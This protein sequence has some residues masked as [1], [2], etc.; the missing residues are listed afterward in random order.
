M[1]F[2]LKAEHIWPTLYN[3]SKRIYISR[4]LL[5]PDACKDGGKWILHAS[6]IKQHI[7]DLL[8]LR[9]SEVS[10]NSPLQV[11]LS[12]QSPEPERLPTDPS[13][14]RPIS[15]DVPWLRSIDI[16]GHSF[17]P[18]T[19]KECHCPVDLQFGKFATMGLITASVRPACGCFCLLGE[20]FGLMTV[21]AQLKPDLPY[22]HKFPCLWSDGSWAC[23]LFSLHGNLSL[24]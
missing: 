12:A 21:H 9:A 14:Q 7:T 4:L 18:W 13:G 24:L 22:P 10:S 5:E 23:C 11:F 16:S 2:I 17:I 19:K 20:C 3:R 15:C 1:C 8:S 6:L